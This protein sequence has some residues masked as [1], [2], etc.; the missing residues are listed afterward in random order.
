MPF[1]LSGSDQRYSLDVLTQLYVISYSV[2]L[3]VS[4]LD[5]HKSNFIYGLHY[6][7]YHLYHLFLLYIFKI[8]KRI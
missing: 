7:N 8:I 5:I 3:N 4:C 6:M 1:C 2:S